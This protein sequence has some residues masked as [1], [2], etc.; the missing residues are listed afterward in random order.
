[1]STFGAGLF[2]G[3]AP[4]ASVAGWWLLAGMGVAAAL[5]FLFAL[6]TPEHVSGPVAPALGVLG[7]L[8]A[9]VA[10]AGTFGAYVLADRPQV[11]AV[12]LV[13]VVTAVVLLAPP[14]PP[15]V[16]R[17]AAGLVL[18]VLVVVAVACF[19]I[20]PEPLAVAPPPDSPGTAAPLGLLPAAVLL[21]VC[22]A[23]APTERRERVGVLGIVLVVC[24]AVAVGA[25]RQ[26][27][28]Q[29]LALSRVPLLDALGAADATSLSLLLALGVTV[30]CAFALRGIL[31]DVRDLAPVGRRPAVTVGLAAV[32]TVLGAVLVE[33]THALVGAGVLL[34]VEAG[35]RMLAGRRRRA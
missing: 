4:A 20:A 11:A 8:C 16:A 26:L 3:L 29:R 22:F 17:V 6:S 25:L 35:F 18:A 9:A 5:A 24:L 12:G 23:G 30:G 15:F 19:T 1:M 27:G 34:L 10:T 2:L 13:V 31:G 28:G 14:L 33:P 21:Y 32:L 7:R